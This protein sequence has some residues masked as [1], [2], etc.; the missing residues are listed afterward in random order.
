MRDNA[1]YL[2]M[3]HWLSSSVVTSNARQHG[4]TNDVR[5]HGLPNDDTLTLNVNNHVAIHVV[6]QS[7]HVRWVF[8]RCLQQ[9]VTRL[10]FTINAWLIICCIALAYSMREII[11]P[12][13]ICHSIC[14]HSHGCISWSISPNWHRHKNP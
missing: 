4:L 11:K 3:T 7:V 13:C 12:V 1:V 6:S 9:T 8:I 14:G 5:Q 2:M 10:K